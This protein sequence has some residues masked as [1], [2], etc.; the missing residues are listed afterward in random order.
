MLLLCLV[1]VSLSLISAQSRPSVRPIPDIPGLLITGRR[2]AAAVSQVPIDPSSNSSDPEPTSPVAPNVELTTQQPNT[3][4]QKT[5][6]SSKNCCQLCLV[7][8]L[9]LPSMIS[10]QFQLPAMPACQGNG[11]S[12]NQVTAFYRGNNHFVACFSATA[13][14]HATLETPEDAEHRTK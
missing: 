7:R 12:G 1:L 9:L 6:N 4:T 8:L 5:E 10:T 13:G 3:I 2:P 11:Q 14:A